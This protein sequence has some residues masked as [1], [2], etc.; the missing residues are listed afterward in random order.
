MRAQ[1]DYSYLALST[2]MT[3]CAL[4]LGTF[5][6]KIV[7]M[8]GGLGWLLILAA[9]CCASIAYGEWSWR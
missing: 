7:L 2:I 6:W 5:G 9:A 3:I 8:G 4:V 1:R